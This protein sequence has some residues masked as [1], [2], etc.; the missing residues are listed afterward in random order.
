MVTLIKGPEQLR[1]HFVPKPR[2]QQPESRTH[3]PWKAMIAGHA[4]DHA[5]GVDDR[6]P[7]RRRDIQSSTRIQAK[8]S[9]LV[10][11]ETGLDC[12][13]RGWTIGECSLGDA[14]IRAT[15][16]APSA[17]IARALT[18]RFGSVSRPNW[19][20][21]PSSILR[22][23]TPSAVPAYRVPSWRRTVRTSSDGRPP[24]VKAEFS[25]CRLPPMRRMTPPSVAIHQARSSTT[26]I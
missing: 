23:P 20:H 24:S 15:Q 22:I 16:S 11:P 26:I 17:S 7:T 8:I 3:A 12:V 1:G 5:L 10:V 18:E 25:A 4:C 6:N 14:C 2:P 9:N 13:I 19:L 21:V